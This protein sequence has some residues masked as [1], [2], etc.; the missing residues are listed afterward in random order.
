MTSSLNLY[1]D[2][3]NNNNNNNELEEEFKKLASLVPTIP[4]NQCLTELEFLEFVIAYIQQLQE[5]L[6]HDQWNECL[7]HL[8]IS[9]KNSFVSSSLDTNLLIKNEKCFQRNPLS[10]INL[11]TNIPHHS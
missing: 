8:T 9:M 5:L 2:D 4:K 1:N 6:S 10:T 7:N 11:D 3:N